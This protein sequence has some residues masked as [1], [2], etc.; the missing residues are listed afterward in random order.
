MSRAQDKT[1]GR[2][3]PCPCGSGKKWKKCHGDQRGAVGTADQTKELFR[4]LDKMNAREID[5]E[6]QQGRGRPIISETFQGYRFVA[7]GPRMYYSN[8]WRTFHDFLFWYLPEVMGGDWGKNELKKSE[9]HPLLGLFRRVGEFKSKHHDSS[10]TI[11]TASGTGAVMAYIGLAYNLYLL[12]HNAQVQTRLLD[13]L[14]D[15]ASFWPAFYETFVAAALIKAGFAVTLEDEGD[16]S[17]TH[18]EFT[19]THRKTGLSFSVEAKRRT[20]GKSHAVVANQ[21]HAALGKRADHTR[22]VFIEMSLA[23]PDTPSSDPMQALPWLREALDSLRS[24]EASLTV[25]GVPAPPAYVVLTNQPFEACLDGVYPGLTVAL[26]GFKIRDAKLDSAFNSVRELRL[27]HERHLPVFEL[28]DSLKSHAAIPMTFDGAI[29][30]FAF[31]ETPRRLII[32]QRYAVSGPD[33]VQ[34]E[35]VLETATVDANR[36]HAI[37]ALRRD[38]GQTIIA[39]FLLSPDELAAYRQYPNTF[40]GVPLKHGGRLESALDIYEFMIRSYGQSSKENLLR[41][42]S[43]H[44]DVEQLRDMAREELAILYSER[45]TEALLRTASPQAKSID[46]SA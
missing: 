28:I 42:M 7:V 23:W 11:Q 13:R 43:D 30:E 36:A 12:A 45:M 17:K 19:A 39:T 1:P 29:P 46:P 14:R 33:G 38:D 44:P 3:D 21:L 8:K 40:F 6:L 35:G 4:Y 20:A 37:G 5:R 16:V 27:A 31:G 2:N 41:L 25:G 10:S 32:G 26:E 18:C 15:A 22:I 9:P 24:K 34:V